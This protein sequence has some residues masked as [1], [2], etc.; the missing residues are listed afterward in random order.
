MTDIE[1]FSS[2]TRIEGACVVWTATR[3][4]KGYGQF[5]LRG[6][7]RQAHRVA[8]ELCVG[9]IPDGMH[10]MHTCDNRACVR[11]AHL[12][13]GTNEDN[14]RDMA[15]KG[16]RRGIGMGESNG[17]AK[18]AAPQVLEIRRSPLGQSALSRQYGVARATIVGI[19]NGRIWRHL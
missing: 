19:I 2:K 3:N 15:K 10:V 7:M 13:L 17:R 12:R 1:R 14:M 6:Q 4:H 16:R 9:V 5:R 18:L 11:P 8:Y